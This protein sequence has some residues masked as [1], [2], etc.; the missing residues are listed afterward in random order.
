MKQDDL[1]R[2]RRFIVSESQK[3]PEWRKRRNELLS[4]EFQ[5]D[6]EKM[7]NNR[8]LNRTTPE[9]VTDLASNEV[10]V[11]GSNL[12]GRHGKGAAKQAMQWG[13]VWGQAAGR[14]GQTYAIPT[15]DASIRRA[16]YPGEIRPYV[17]KFTE[18]AR[19]HPRTTFVV[20]EIGC[21]LAGMDPKYI[22]PMF[23]EASELDNVLLPA[24]FRA[25]IVGRML[26]RSRDVIYG[27]MV[28]VDID[29][30]A[31]FVWCD[32]DL[33]QVMDGAEPPQD[34]TVKVPSTPGVYRGTVNATWSCS[35]TPDAHNEWEMVTSG[36]RWGKAITPDSY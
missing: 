2:L 30:C 31:H 25:E 9:H 18:Y 15:K 34:W 17:E 24:R 35:N 1:H 36:V 29:G 12:A 4:A 33:A 5:T 32:P 21:G 13:A 23:D 27:C 16:L 26:T 10:F 3:Q 7:T 14:Q 8:M 28:A 19:A 22:A 6:D 20:T 11:F